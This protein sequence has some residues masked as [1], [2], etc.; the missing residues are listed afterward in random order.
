[1]NL[2]LAEVHRLRVKFAFE[3]YNQT[4]LTKDKN[5]YEKRRVKLN[6]ANDYNRQLYG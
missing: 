5:P 6:S 2:N 1:M 4:F 3:N